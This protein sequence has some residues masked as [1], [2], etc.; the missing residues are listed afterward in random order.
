MP[1]NDELTA[2]QNTALAAT[3][4]TTQMLP[5]GEMGLSVVKMFLTLIVLIALLFLSY[6]LLRRFVQ[7]RLQKG[8]R[9]AAIQILEKRMLSPKTILYL[10]EVDQKKILLA[11]SHLEIKRLETFGPPVEPS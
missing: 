11:E 4:A 1:E 3:D 6:W 5:P 10:V 8:N 7:Q 9:E 2:F